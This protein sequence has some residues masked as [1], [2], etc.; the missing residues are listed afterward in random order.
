MVC[1]EKVVVL[2]CGMLVLVYYL[3]FV[4]L[5]NWLGMKE[6][7]VFELK[8]GVELSSGYLIGLLMK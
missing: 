2:L 1:W 5:V 6:V 8:F 4:Y 7:G 3:F